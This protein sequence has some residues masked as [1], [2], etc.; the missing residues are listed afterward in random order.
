MNSL[1]I[2]EYP[3]RWFVVGSVALTLFVLSF[4]LVITFSA[5]SLFDGIIIGVWLFLSIFNLFYTFELG[6]WI[7]KKEPTLY[8]QYLAKRQMPYMPVAG[9][10][11]FGGFKELVEKEKL[12]SFV[13]F[14]RLTLFVGQGIA[15]ILLII[16]VWL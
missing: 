15:N 6:V 10:A 5:P 2:K 13:L 4:G 12:K 16:F 1:K 11:Y 7:V 3:T 8:D 9:S 14:G